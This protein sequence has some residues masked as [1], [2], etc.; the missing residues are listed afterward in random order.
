MR[1]SSFKAFTFSVE[2]LYFHHFIF[3]MCPDNDSVIA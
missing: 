2:L 1:I 3:S